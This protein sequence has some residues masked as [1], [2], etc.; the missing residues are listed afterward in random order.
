MNFNLNSPLLQG[1]EVIKFP[2]GVEREVLGH[3]QKLHVDLALKKLVDNKGNI[4]SNFFESRSFKKGIKESLQKLLEYSYVENIVELFESDFSQYF[5]NIV[6]DLE[7]Q[8][9]WQICATNLISDSK[10]NDLTKLSEIFDVQSFKEVDDINK[11]KE[12]A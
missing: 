1:T 6:S 7:I 5:K 2:V 8:K 3:L 10:Y 9:A 4:P 12:I 11:N